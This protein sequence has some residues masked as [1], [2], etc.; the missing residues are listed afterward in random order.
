MRLI[1]FHWL[2]LL[3]VFSPEIKFPAAPNNRRHSGTRAQQRQARKARNR[4]RARGRK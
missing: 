1:P 4:R 2:S 3:G